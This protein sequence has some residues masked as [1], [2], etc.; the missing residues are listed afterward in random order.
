MFMTVFFTDNEDKNSWKLTR[1]SLNMKDW[2]KKSTRIYEDVP[3]EDR[4][5]NCLLLEKN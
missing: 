3:E 2:G 4:F 1:F 5:N